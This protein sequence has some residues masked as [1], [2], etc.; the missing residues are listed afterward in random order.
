MDENK[1]LPPVDEERQ[2]DWVFRFLKG[3]GI[4]FSLCIPFIAVFTYLYH[5]LYAV[6]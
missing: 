5:V 4:G 1:K 6:S 2:F 3:I